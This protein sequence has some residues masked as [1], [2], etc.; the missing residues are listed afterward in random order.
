MIGWAE[1][2]L[3]V[4]LSLIFLG[5]DGIVK[6][7]R[8]LGR[9]YAQY[10]KLLLEIEMERRKLGKE[11]EVKSEWNNKGDLDEKAQTHRQNE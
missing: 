11:L 7:M 4:I 1:F 9:L 6:V 8:F 5:E 2:T 10:R 3:I